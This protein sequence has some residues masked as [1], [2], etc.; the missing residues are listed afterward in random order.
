M[1]WGLMVK[2]LERI[3]VV[4]FHEKPDEAELFNRSLIFLWEAQ[5]RGLRVEA[6]KYGGR[7]VD[8]FR[9]TYRN[10]SY[11]YESIPLTLFDDAVSFRDKLSVKRILQNHGIPVAMG[12]RFVNNEQ[13]MQYG[14]GLGYPLVAKPASGTLSQHV[15]CPIRSRDEL[16]EAITIAQLC[17]PDILVER[18]ITGNLYRATVV[19]GTHV[20]VCQRE[21]ANVVG[22]GHS[23]VEELI[24][25]KNTGP[26]R[27]ETYQKN[28]TLHKIPIDDMLI[29][30]LQIQ[31]LNLQSV[32]ALGSK[33]YLH[34]KLILSRGCDLHNRTSVT[35][36]DNRNLFLKIAKVMGFQIIGIDFI[37]PDIQRSYTQQGTAVLEC[38]SLPFVDMHQFPSHGTPEPIAQVIWDVVLEKLTSDPKLGIR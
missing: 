36:D 37:C 18:Y 23:T 28:T 32:L 30:N 24:T 14:E 12:E 3:G 21:K 33:I 38:N 26:N 8:E 17:R 31:G 29:H 7:Y 6:V 15:T 19:G 20:F 11:F 2:I 22:D 13:A 16:R 25:L 4:S 35:H 27:G 5:K 34:N 1:K 10:K 9:L